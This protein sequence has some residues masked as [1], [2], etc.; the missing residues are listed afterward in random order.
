M[1]TGLVTAGELERELPRVYRVAGAPSGLLGDMWAAVLYAGPGA[2]L[3]GVAGAYQAGWLIYP[4]SVIEVSTPRH[5]RS[6]RRIEV[7]GRRATPRHL[8]EGGLPVLDTPLLVRDLGASASGRPGLTLVRRALAVLDFRHQLDSDAL[9][10]VCGRGLPGSATVRWAI[11]HYDPLFAKTNG[12]FEEDWLWLCEDQD[13]PK[14]DDMG[15]VILGV[16]CD[17]VYFDARVIVELDGGA[18]HHSAAQTQKNHADDLLLRSHDW[19]VLRYS[20]PLVHARPKAVRADVLAALA[21]R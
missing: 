2:A 11:E 1:R 8:V 10:A 12:V 20:W 4:P 14:P 13:I 6:R 18:N 7:R 19:T 5:C 16:E 3:T 21:H 17:A 15:V 9:L